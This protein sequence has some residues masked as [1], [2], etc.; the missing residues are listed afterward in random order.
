MSPI[1]SMDRILS[2]AQKDPVFLEILDELA[3]PSHDHINVTGMTDSQKAYLVSALCKKTGQKPVILVPDEL[4]ARTMQMDL[5]AFCEDDV[6]ILRQRELNF[7]DVDASSREAELSRIGVLRRL[8]TGEFGAVIITAGALL[9]RLMPVSEFQSSLVT[10]RVGMRVRPEDL[11]MRLVNIGYERSRK[12]EGEGEFARRGDIFD[13][14]PAGSDEPVRISFFD[15]DIDQIKS[16]DMETQRS[17]AQLKEVHIPLGRELLVP[18]ARRADISRR[19]LEEGEKAR[20]EAAQNGADRDV[21]ENLLRLSAQDAERITE[22]LLFFGLEKWTPILLPQ[23]ASVL[24]YVRSCPYL[25]FL[26]EALSFRKRLDSSQADF[27]Q[28]FSALFEKGQVLPLSAGAVWKGSELFIELDQKGRVITLSGLPTSGN[29]L[30]GASGFTIPGRASESFRGHEENL[31]KMIT[32]RRKDNKE[33]ILM[34]GEGARADRLREFLAERNTFSEIF[35]RHLTAGFEYPAAGLLIVGTQDIFGIDRPMRRK[36]SQGVHIDLFSDL[37]PGELVVHEQHGIGRYDGMVN[38]EA[39]G[40]RRDYLKITYASEDSLYI[41]M[42]KLDQIQKYVGSEGRTPK[43]SRLGGQEWNRM[44]EKARASIRKLAF[45]LVELYAQRQAIKGHMFAPDSVWQREFEEDFPYQ[46]TEDQLTAIAD[47]KSDME[48]DKVMD[49]LLCGDVGFGKTEVAFRAI[50]KCIMDGKQAILLAPTTV[51]VQQHYENLRERL[52]RFPVKVGLL[53]RFATPAMIKQTVKGLHDGS[54]DVVV[55]THRILSKDIVP[56]DIGLLVVDEEQRFGVEHKEKLKALRTSVDVLTLTATPIPRT[57]HMSLSGIRDISILEEPPLDRRP[58]QTYVMEYD[59]DIIN[60]ACLREISRQGQVFYLFN[61]THRIIEKVT[62]LEKAL[63]GARITYAHGKMGERQLENIIESFIFH[64]AD[65]LV[66]TTIIESGIDMPNV[67][68]IIVEDADRFG[69]AQLYQLKGRVGRSDRQAYAYITYRR[70]KI[71]TEVAEKRLTAIRDFTELGSGIKI[72]LKDLEVRGAGNLLG[73]EQHGQMDVI[74]YDLYC[75][76]LEEEI[77]IIQAGN[78]GKAITPARQAVIEIDIDAYITPEYIHDDGQRM[79][80]YRRISEIKSSREYMDVLDELMDR[81][82]E[83]PRQVQILTDI[84]YIRQMA[85]RF[86][87]SRILVKDEQVLLYYVEDARPD[88]EALSKILA[89]PDFKGRILFSAMQKPYIQYRPAP[90]DRG[91]ITDRLREFFRIL[92]GGS[93]S[94]Q[95]QIEATP[96]AKT[97]DA[98]KAC[99]P[100][101]LS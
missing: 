43:L 72:A 26:D 30:P 22:G 76:M 38:L 20:L 52:S 77:K 81:Y 62:A 84:S 92:E 14:F 33:T 88:M 95:A 79:D 78:E 66:C 12:V 51:L 36:K 74:G 89:H 5:S 2:M 47:I 101:N 11:A 6:L 27:V 21:C 25:L 13:V 45:D 32:Q 39:G 57:L 7:A 53:S 34:A 16:F 15:E 40:V 73:A 96:R 64:E 56:K 10:L 99:P 9:N 65:I 80:A 90:K 50:F 63:P 31:A 69:L 19:I 23:S 100:V 83:V 18:E 93:D 61:D 44:K 37:V 42:E 75:R 59:E 29:G 54:I 48:S 97:D 68:T 82:G 87:F 46:E 91:Q 86:G 1:E 94:T 28:R 4:R 67:N 35:P 85:G 58:V 8:L 41:S 71:L 55:G 24:S 60:E 49:R 3:V 17:T 70:D 98:A